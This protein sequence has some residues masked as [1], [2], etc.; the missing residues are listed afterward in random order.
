MADYDFTPESYL[1]MMREAVPGYD[2][3][4][5]EIAAATG[6]GAKSVL[7][8]GTGTGETARRVLDRHPD[9][10]LIGIDASPGMVKVARESLPT[11]R[12]RLLVGRLEDPLPEGPFDLVVSC[13]GVHH[14]EG[15]SKADLFRRIARKLAPGGRFVLADV[16]EPV[17]P[18]YVVTAI[19]PE[20]DHPSKL[21]EQV[22]WLEAAGMLPRVT[23]T[24]RDLVVIV[25]TLMDGTS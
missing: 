12:V 14:L 19:D 9:A 4:E 21:D 11:D 5:E 22:A 3:L 13:L 24:H 8:L 17:D 23:W 16:V 1:A 20:I 15:T 10:Q 2:R 18:S 25:A 6:A 7:E